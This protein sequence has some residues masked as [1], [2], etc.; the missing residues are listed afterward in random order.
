M[1][2]I[3]QINPAPQLPTS[4][5]GS[6][7]LT[8]AAGERLRVMLDGFNLSLEKGTGVATYSRNLSFCLR[9]LQCDVGVLY[10]GGAT[11]HHSDLIKEVSFYDSQSLSL[12]KWQRIR[13]RLRALATPNRNSAFEVPIT[14]QV[15]PDTFQARLPHFKTIWNATDIYL[16]AASQ[17]DIFGAVN[18]V[19][20]DPVPD[21]FHWTYPLPIRAKGC[22]NI[23]TLH[24]IVP[25][26]LPYS[27]L[28]KKDKYLKLLKWIAQTADHVVTVSEASRRDLID[29]VGFAPEQVTN[30]YQAVSIPAKYLTK[31]E[32]AVRSE[33]E[34]MFGLQFKD[35]Y[36][37]F[38]SIEPKKNV[39]RLI[40]AYLAS[41]VQGPLVIVGAQAWKSEQELRLLRSLQNSGL[42]RRVV[43]LEYASYPLLLTLIRGARGVLFPSLYEGFGLPILEAML[44]GTPVLSSNTSSIPEVAGDAALLVNPYDTHDIAEGIRAL[45]TNEYLRD[46]LVARG[47]LQAQIFSEAAYRARLEKVY[48]RVATRQKRNRT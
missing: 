9:D 22:P 38:G 39:G 42:Q 28:D 16:K 24:D 6:I 43:Q 5:E 40:E 15:V 26:R 45:D 21:V 33:V 19:S 34:G 25:L 44:L 4:S 2:A 47:V 31:S 37:F 29:I 3:V 41:G 8:N 18:Q 10:G 12:G 11:K 27:T 36:L 46:E 13:K 32:A 20:I 14:G 23:Y 17:F 35:Y 48:A 30:T 7:R 1:N